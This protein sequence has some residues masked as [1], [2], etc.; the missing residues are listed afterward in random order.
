MTP[1]DRVELTELLEGVMV[2]VDDNFNAGKEEYVDKLS[3]LQSTAGPALARAMG[4]DIQMPTSYQQG[5]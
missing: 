1:E 4:L 2:W 5:F 3:A